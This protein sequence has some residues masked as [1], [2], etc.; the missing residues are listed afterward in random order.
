MTLATIRAF[1]A[2]CHGT[3]DVVVTMGTHQT[4]DVLNVIAVCDTD[5]IAAPAGWTKKCT[6]FL[7]GIA[8]SLLQRDTLAA[9]NAEGSM[10]IIDPGNHCMAVAFAHDGDPEL[11]NFAASVMV[12]ST[13]TARFSSLKTE[14]DDITALMVIGT[15][16]TGTPGTGFASAFTNADLASITE[17]FDDMCNDGNG[18]GIAVAKATKVVPGTIGQG[19]ATVTA[20]NTAT[21]MLLIKPRAATAFS[22]VA[23][24]D[25]GGFAANGT[26]VKIVDTTQPDVVFTATVAGGAGAFSGL[27]RFDDHTYVAFADNGTKRGA[28][29]EAV[30]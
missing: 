3:G 23:S 1:G 7:T 5:T 29:I 19:V 16:I 4:G 22:G 12:G 18:S 13:T 26:V 8:V 2:N 9:S 6:A 11:L 27:V 25:S 21:L 28:A 17:V 14:M 20:G 15:S 24:I 10:T 30:P